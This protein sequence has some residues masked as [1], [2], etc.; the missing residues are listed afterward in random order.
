MPMFSHL[1]SPSTG[2]HLHHIILKKKRKKK[3]KAKKKPQIFTQ[4]HSSVQTC[5][6]GKRNGKLN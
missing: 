4:S 1:S 3:G 5:E 2:K 6:R